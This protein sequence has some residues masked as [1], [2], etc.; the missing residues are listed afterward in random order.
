MELH[1]IFRKTKTFL[2]RMV[3]ISSFNQSIEKERKRKEP[4]N[5]LID[6]AKRKGSF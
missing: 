6:E 4:T 3:T 2:S 1:R 5:N